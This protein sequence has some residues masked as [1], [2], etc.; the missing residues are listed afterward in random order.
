MGKNSVQQGVATEKVTGKRT[1]DAM[2]QR[3]EDAS[4]YTLIHKIPCHKA[5]MCGRTSTTYTVAYSQVSRILS[6]VLT[7]KASP[8]CRLLV[9]ESRNRA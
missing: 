4:F 7:H 2:E 8:E 5:T 9:R 3:V 1:V 6:T